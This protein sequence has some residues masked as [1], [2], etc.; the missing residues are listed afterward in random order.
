MEYF[1]SKL[2]DREFESLAGDIISTHLN[3]NVEKF[4]A[5]R[6]G[7][8]DGRFWIGKKEGVLQCKHYWK[9]GYQGLIS[10][11][12]R[13][14]V[15]KV[16]KL[17]PARYIF[18][19]S[20]PLSRKNKKEILKIFSPFIKSETDV[21]GEDDIND[22]LSKKENQNIVEKN[23]KLWITSTQ[24]LDILLNNAIKGRSESTIKEIESHNERYVITENH[25]KGSEILKKNNVIIITGDPGI[26]KTTLA[27]NLALYY[28]ANGFEF[29]D[30]EESISEAEDLF[31]EK[32]KKKIIFYCD[33]F[34]GSNM[35][36]AISN[37]RDSHI[38]KFINRIKSDNS[39]KFILTSRTNILT[40][41]VSLSHQFQNSKIRDDEFLLKIENLSEI[42]KAKILYN[43]IYHSDLD[44]IYIDEL[45]KEK[46]YKEIIRHRNFNPRI[47]EFI[48]DDKRVSK[49]K[50]EQYWNYITNKF[51]N[52]EDIWSD[53]FQNQIDDSVR[54]LSFL[55]VFNGSRIDEQ[56][57][58]RSYSSFKN[59]F[60]IHFSD[61]TD[62]SFNAVRKLAIKSLLNRSQTWNNN[63]EYSL[64]NPSVGDFILNSYLED[65]DLVISIL[66]SLGTD[67]SIDFLNSLQLNNRISKETIQQVQFELFNYLYEAKLGNKDWDYLILLSYLDIFNPRTTNT[68]KDL[69]KEIS[70]NKES[71][72]KRLYELL[73]LL[74]EFDERIDIQD[75]SF[76]SEFIENKVIDSDDIE[77]LLELIKRYKIED[78][79]FIEKFSLAV[80][81]YIRDTLNDNKSSAD[82]GEHIRF[83][84]Y[85]EQEEMDVDYEGI[86][87]EMESIL[88]SIVSEFDE[89]LLNYAYIDQSDILASIDIEQE[90]ES[91]A[92]SFGD[93]NEDEFRGRTSSYTDSENDI[94]N[95]FERS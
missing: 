61:N 1:L 88:D 63:F 40:K 52:P 28:M 9:T 86:N 34:L 30:I 46:R 72:G 79:S 74:V 90:I 42:D 21:W 64:F 67:S 5:G 58:R 87:C 44:N 78:E 75:F 68:I 2:N 32:E 6:D 82:I 76:V 92:N 17:N 54:V 27:N 66:K 23:Y 4:K 10:K 80:D 91:Y 24:I 55:T 94:D 49:I 95:I 77:K 26:G 22:F 41:A 48:T 33:D 35:Y 16:N 51:E 83:S 31:R 13:E 47:I 70:N 20:V 59:N 93:Y 71:A 85:L 43:H 12:K 45:Y 14:E 11:L 81:S 18:F 69:I 37:K 60:S 38:V 53:Y 7:G 65:V 3:L 19:T 29:C 62:S 25:L 89:E 15:N 84:Y 36:D 50:S 73:I 8:I 57:L 39:K 56:E